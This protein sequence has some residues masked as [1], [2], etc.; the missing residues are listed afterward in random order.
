[1]T[2]P[3][4]RV[5]WNWRDRDPEREQA[6]IRETL[7][8]EGLVQG[9][10]VLAI[11]LV[12]RHLVGHGVVGGVL[13]ILGAVQALCGMWRPLWLRPVR[14]L[15]R[16][17]GHAVGLALAWLLLV[18]LHLLVVT[19]AAWLLRLQGRDPL[20]RQPL[21]ANLTAWIPRRRASTPASL[22]RQFLEEDREARR[23]QR[24]E[25]VR[26]DPRLLADLEP[27]RS[28]GEAGA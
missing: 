13:V 27:D 23:L 15:G 4:S 12:L 18:P 3:A 21:P 2:E 16:R 11:G 8:R 9:F 25:G 20:H 28:A 6:R 7:R 1:V 14:R 19:P 10:V 24:S 17:L 5:V 22:E 26:P